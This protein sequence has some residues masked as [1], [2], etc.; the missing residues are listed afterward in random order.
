VPIFLLP[1]LKFFCIYTELNS[2]RPGSAEHS[3]QASQPRPLVNFPNIN[4]PQRSTSKNSRL[5]IQLAMDTVGVAVCPLF[6]ASFREY[7]PN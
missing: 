1:P 5:T 4:V 3:V 7:V 2:I 6:V